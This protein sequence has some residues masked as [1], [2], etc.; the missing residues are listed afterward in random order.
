MIGLPAW[1]LRMLCL[2]M[3]YPCRIC[4]FICILGHQM[5]WCFIAIYKH[6]LLK[7]MNRADLFLQKY[8]HVCFILFNSLLFF[9]LCVFVKVDTNLN[10]VQLYMH[11]LYS[12]QS[13]LP[14]ADCIWVKELRAWIYC[15][16]VYIHYFYCDNSWNH[17]KK[18]RCSRRTAINPSSQFFDSNKYIYIYIYIYRERERER[19]SHHFSIS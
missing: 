13:P 18:L 17:L 11:M 8:V 9:F 7:L 2:M 15:V 6:F 4:F 14:R 12:P 19:E 1:S 3:P 16:C 5:I 10:P